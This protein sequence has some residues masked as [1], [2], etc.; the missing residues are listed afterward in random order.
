M[1]EESRTTL[2]GHRCRYE[3]SFLSSAA[4]VH[5]SPQF[6]HSQEFTG[7]TLSSTGS[8]A[9]HF[10]HTGGSYS[11]TSIL[12]CSRMACGIGLE[13]ISSACSSWSAA[14]RIRGLPVCNVI[15]SAPSIQL[16]DSRLPSTLA[17]SGPP[18]P[19]HRIRRAA[20]SMYI[21]AADRSPPLRHQPSGK[22]RKDQA[23][24]PGNSL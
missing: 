12:D 4:S 3:G 7:S 2:G 5:C 24:E 16:V 23:E 19:A 14:T 20:S 9:P 15:E 8:S 22:G 6:S 10:G 21:P 18:L 11:G 1:H 17:G 13:R